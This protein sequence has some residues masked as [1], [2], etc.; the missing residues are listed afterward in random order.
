MGKTHGKRSDTPP[1]TAVG[2]IGGCLVGRM[3]Y[4]AEYVLLLEDVCLLLFV[5]PEE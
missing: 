1:T 4:G 2:E 3:V 5:L